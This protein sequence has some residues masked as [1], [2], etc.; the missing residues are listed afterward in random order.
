MLPLIICLISITFL[1]KKR[2]SKPNNIKRT[3]QDLKVA[4]S[5]FNKLYSTGRQ[6]SRENLSKLEMD[7]EIVAYCF[8]ET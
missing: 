8:L 6:L 4:S 2:S 5:I 7:K 3:I 1:R